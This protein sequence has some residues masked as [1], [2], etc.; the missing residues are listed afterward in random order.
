MKKI[1]LALALSLASQ[2]VIAQDAPTT[3]LSSGTIRATDQKVLSQ[4]P[5]EHFNN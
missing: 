2:Y 3:L 1:L 4:Y 5:L